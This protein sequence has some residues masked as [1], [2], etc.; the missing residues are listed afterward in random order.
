MARLI[1]AKGYR[2]MTELCWRS[3]SGGH[4]LAGRS[5]GSCA[6]DRSKQQCRLARSE[7]FDPGMRSLHGLWLVDPHF[8]TSSSLDDGPTPR[9]PAALKA[10]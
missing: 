1:E 4:R 9:G 7:R 6:C 2:L 3:R 10:G 8:S 5:A